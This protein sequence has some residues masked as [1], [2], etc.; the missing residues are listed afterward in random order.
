MDANPCESLKCPFGFMP[1]GFHFGKK[2]SARRSFFGPFLGA[3]EVSEA[4]LALNLFG[5]TIARAMREHKVKR[6][7][8][9]GQ[10]P[11]WKVAN[12]QFVCR[13]DQTVSGL[14]CQPRNQPKG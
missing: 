3:S 5:P 2:G 10:W 13:L 12:G 9:R 1:I 8:F 14:Q 4:A 7:W 6:F 11:K